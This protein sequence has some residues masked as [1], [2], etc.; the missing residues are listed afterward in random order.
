MTK[1]IIITGSSGGIG[2][3]LVKAFKYHGWNVLGIDKVVNSEL[4]E[5]YLCN[6]FINFDLALCKDKEVLKNLIQNIRNYFEAS[7]GH[8]NGIINNAALQIIKPFEEISSKEWDKLLA[9]NLIAPVELSK[10]FMPDLKRNRGSIINIGSIHINL[11]KPL[12]S[13]YAVSKG[14]LKTLTQSLAVEFGDK[15]RVNMIEPAA[16]ETPMLLEGFKNDSKNLDYLKKLHPTKMIGDP[17]DIANAA[18]F[19]MDHNQKFLNGTSLKLTGGIH[20]K[21]HDIY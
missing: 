18:L 9:V 20:C 10:A 1:S 14:A 4:K 11:T 13:S 19:L 2:L 15:V 12:F 16:I 7:N 3:S 5:E 6:K 17:D 21:L 8:L